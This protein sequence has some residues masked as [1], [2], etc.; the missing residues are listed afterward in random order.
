M[1]KKVAQVLFLGVAAL[2]KRLGVDNFGKVGQNP[3]LAR[4]FLDCI[5]Y[6]K[7]IKEN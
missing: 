1:C 7:P 5:S 6:T 4:I 2:I 3:R